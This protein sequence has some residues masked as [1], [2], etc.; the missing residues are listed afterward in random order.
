[1]KKGEGRYVGVSVGNAG[2]ALD[3]TGVAMLLPKIAAASARM[4][5]FIL[6]MVEVASPND[7]VVG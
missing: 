6:E 1:M 5:S 3:C 4:V 2:A 7:K